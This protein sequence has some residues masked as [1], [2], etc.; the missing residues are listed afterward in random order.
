M[1][2]GTATLMIDDALFT[3]LA[4]VGIEKARDRLPAII[5]NVPLTRLTVATHPH[6]IEVRGLGPIKP[7]LQ[8][9]VDANGQIALKLQVN[10]FDLSPLT[11]TLAQLLNDEVAQLRQLTEAQGLSFHLRQVQ[12]RPNEFVIIADVSDA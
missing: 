9:S 7:I 10:I 11:E 8:P 3:L 5:R 1:A 6:G 4:H 2:T 12:T